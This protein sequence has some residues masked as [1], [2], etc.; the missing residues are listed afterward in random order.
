MSPRLPLPQAPHRCSRRGT[1]APG[2]CEGRGALETP[3]PPTSQ[4]EVASEP[5]GSPGMAWSLVTV[6]LLSSLTSAS[7]ASG[8][9]T[10]LLQG[11]LVKPARQKVGVQVCGKTA[12]LQTRAAGSRTLLPTARA[13]TPSSRLRAVSSIPKR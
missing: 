5:S 10:S 8:V 7:W 12:A 13:P 6:T 11:P 3:P 1:P 2:L 4:P 9:S